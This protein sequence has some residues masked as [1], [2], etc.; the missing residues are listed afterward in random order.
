MP[1]PSQEVVIVI[2]AFEP[3]VHLTK[4]LD[5]L[6]E[7]PLPIVV[8]DDGSGE[9]FQAIFDEAAKHPQV[10]VLK[11]A[12]NLGKGQALKT[13]FNYVLN[14]YPNAT[15][16]VTADADGQ[17]LPENIMGV[18]KALNEKPHH[19]ILGARHFTGKVPLRSKFGN[20]VTRYVFATMIGK[21][22]TDTQT[23]LRG[24]PAE[25]LQTCLKIH[26]T[27]YEFELQMLIEAVG[28]HLPIDELPIATIYE[29]NNESSHFNPLLDS[30]KIYFVFLRFSAIGLVT[31]LVD[32]LMFV[33]CFAFTHHLFFSECMARTS[34]GLFSFAIGKKWV[35]KSNDHVLLELTKFTTL[36]AT[37]LLVSYGLIYTLVNVLN[38][39][40]YLS[41]ILIQT[42]LFFA[43][44]SIQRLFVF[45]YKPKLWLSQRLKDDA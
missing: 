32:L 35:F 7:Q 12:V 39:N 15:G 29:N 33:F 25:F 13:A 30:L 20:V 44:F 8:V 21:K 45:R 14:E 16:V 43:S 3:D 4:L 31:A 6:C 10:T 27:G 38:M 26:S 36:W 40:V 23:G 19:L 5:K 9:R 41:K 24:I 37:L 11:H 22:L 18:A 42:L 34:G 28:A 17:H 2:P 1:K